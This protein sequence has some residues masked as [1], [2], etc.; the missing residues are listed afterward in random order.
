MAVSGEFT[1]V[2]QVSS[3]LDT[4]EGATIVL[5]GDYSGWVTVEISVDG[6]GARYAP[7]GTINDK[8]AVNVTCFGDTKIRLVCIKLTSGTITYDMNAN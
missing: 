6:V 7:A 1:A 4:I 5:S 8:G 3:A 2:G